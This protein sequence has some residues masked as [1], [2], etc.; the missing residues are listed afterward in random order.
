M[1]FACIAMVR[2]SC[3]FGLQVSGQFVTAVTVG[4]AHE[5][6]S[7]EKTIIG[8]LIDKLRV[9]GELQPNDLDLLPF[10]TM[11]EW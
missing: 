5:V 2:I 3:P 10:N 1:M 8:G 9:Q 7:R 6:N 4:N 11:R